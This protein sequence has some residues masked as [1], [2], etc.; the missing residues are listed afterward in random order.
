MSVQKLVGEND[1]LRV[2]AIAIPCRAIFVSIAT[3]CVSAIVQM[4]DVE[5]DRTSNFQVRVTFFERKA[6]WYSTTE[7]FTNLSV[8][9]WGLIPIQNIGKKRSGMTNQGWSKSVP[10]RYFLC[11]AATSQQQAKYSTRLTLISIYTF[12]YIDYK[13]MKVEKCTHFSIICQEWVIR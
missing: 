8:E 4:R 1:C 9:S 12:V 3:C 11:S 13:L 7:S 6:W 2:N 10:N 5:M